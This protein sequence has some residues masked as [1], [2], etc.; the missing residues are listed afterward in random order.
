VCVRVVSVYVV[1]C[2]FFK[3]KLNSSSS[4]ILF[5]LSSLAIRTLKWWF[6]LLGFSCSLAQSEVPPN[7]LYDVLGWSHRTAVRLSAPRYATPTAQHPGVR[8]WRFFICTGVR[9][10]RRHGPVS[11][12]KPHSQ[13]TYRATPSGDV[14]WGP[15]TPA[16]SPITPPA[17]GRWEGE[18][19]APPAEWTEQPTI[20]ATAKQPGAGRSRAQK[21][22]GGAEQEAAGR[23]SR[24]RAAPDAGG[25]RSK[26]H[27]TASGPPW[28]DLD[29][30]ADDGGLPERI[31][32]STRGG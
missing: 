14:A 22:R 21:R 30:L 24:R 1:L 25:R 3:K 31:K 27:L 32:M 13:C 26:R 28:L 6:P 10:D 20:C 16:R 9:Y 23:S 5:Q 11:A 15:R 8:L 29:A 4:E 18:A 17:Q 2:I 19:R 12:L 7:V